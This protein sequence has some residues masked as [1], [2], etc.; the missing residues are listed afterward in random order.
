MF[1]LSLH[2]CKIEFDIVD[3]RFIPAPIL[4]H[5]PTVSCQ[6]GEARTAADSARPGPAEEPALT[7]VRPRSA[8]HTEAVWTPLEALTI[9]RTCHLALKSCQFFTAKQ[10][11]RG[12]CAW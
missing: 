7:M 10:K 9:A 5:N 4:L 8:A 11:K 6:P 12:F 2:R 3:G 1:V